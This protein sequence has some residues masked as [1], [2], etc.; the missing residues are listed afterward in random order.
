[1]LVAQAKYAASGQSVCVGGGLTIHVL[2]Y[3][4][5]KKSLIQAHNQIEKR[6]WWPGYET[7]KEVSAGHWMRGLA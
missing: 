3:K 4:K 2:R 6:E 7:W 1:M 5:W